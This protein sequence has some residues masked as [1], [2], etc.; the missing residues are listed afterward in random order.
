MQTRNDAT[1]IA[2]TLLSDPPCATLGP[3]HMQ[4]LRRGSDAGARLFRE[5]AVGVVEQLDPLDRVR[6]DHL[7]HS[8]AAQL[9]ELLLEPAIG[10]NKHDKGCT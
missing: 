8:R 6:E 9:A 10:T 7:R 4:A 2:N 5:L 1:Q 3:R